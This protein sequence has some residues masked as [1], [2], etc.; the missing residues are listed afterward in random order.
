LARI[1]PLALCLVNPLSEF[2]TSMVLNLAAD[3]WHTG[4]VAD[5]FRSAGAVCALGVGE[6][7]LLEVA[8]NISLEL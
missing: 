7:V 5:V 4:D 8:D 3:T 2:E 6:S 1:D